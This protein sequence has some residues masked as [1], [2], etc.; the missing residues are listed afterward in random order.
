MV[1]KIGASVCFRARPGQG[2]ALAGLLA[3][4]GETV[5]RRAGTELW[6]VHR[7][8]D[9]SD[10]VWLWEVFA[11]EQAR[12]AHGMQPAYLEALPRI[13]A[14]LAEPPQIELVIPY[15]G[16]GLMSPPGG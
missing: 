5:G 15:A 14:L 6:L 1:R 12:E 2:D 13:E 4:L 10:V 3:T 8:P 9:R 11:S 7:A 16:K